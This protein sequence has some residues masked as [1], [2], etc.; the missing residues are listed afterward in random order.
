MGA[1]WVMGFETGHVGF[2]GGPVWWANERVLHGYLWL[3]Y[4]LMGESL[5][6]VADT[7]L[8]VVNWVK[9]HQD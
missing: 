9:A 5:F 1:R 7:C 2:F 3:A 4:A 6:L 8:G